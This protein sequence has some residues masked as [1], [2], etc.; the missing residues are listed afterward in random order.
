MEFLLEPGPPVPTTRGGRA[1][2]V[3]LSAFEWGQANMKIV[4]MVVL[5]VCCAPSARMLMADGGAGG[6]KLSFFSG[7]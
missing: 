7:L 5:V 1:L 3:G 6:Q 4:R 2:R